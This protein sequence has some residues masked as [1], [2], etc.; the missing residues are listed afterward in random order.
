MSTIFPIYWD[1]DPVPKRT[2]TALIYI[3]QLNKKSSLI[4]ESDRIK[5]ENK[6]H[7]SDGG[8][9]GYITLQGNNL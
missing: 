4:E 1:T 7:S 9:L 3:V 6:N 5:E 2:V 8:N